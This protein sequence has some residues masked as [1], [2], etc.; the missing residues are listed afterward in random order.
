[1]IIEQEQIAP[2]VNCSR[3]AHTQGRDVTPLIGLSPADCLQIEQIFTRNLA[4]GRAKRVSGR[5]RGQPCEMDAG[6][7]S[8]FAAL[9]GSD[10]EPWHCCYLHRLT[11]VYRQEHLRLNRLAQG[12]HDAWHALATQLAKSAYRLLLHRGISAD[13]AV[14]M[15]K[16]AAQQTCIRFYAS[17]FPYDVAF[18][19]WVHLI[20]KNVILHTLTRSGDLLDR[21]HT[22]SLDHLPFELDDLSLSVI[23][24]YAATAPNPSHWPHSG[25][26]EDRDWIVRALEKMANPQRRAV[27]IFTY[28]YELNDDE[29]ALQLG[30]SKGAIYTLRHRALKQLH[31]VLSNSNNL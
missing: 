3:F 2:P 29:I 9:A 14:E 18:D 13:L 17:T 10:L 7:G 23:A 16:D 21:G 30:K 24:S 31:Q 15:A 8:V 6:A 22:D 11:Q 25:Q 1:M 19:A 27:I 4:S 12:D 26:I 5:L 20:L 28:F